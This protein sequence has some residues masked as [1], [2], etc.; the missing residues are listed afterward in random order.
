MTPITLCVNGD[1]RP[2]RPP[3]KVLCL[4]CLKELDRKMHEMLQRLDPLAVPGE[5]SK[6]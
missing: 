5:G 4:E 3:S 2:T 6:P 1:G